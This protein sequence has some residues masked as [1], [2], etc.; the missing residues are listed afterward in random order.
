MFSELR[1]DKSLPGI[2]IPKK[3]ERKGLITLIQQE[4]SELILFEIS[5]LNYP[6]KL[7]V[8]LRFVLMSNKLFRDICNSL[9]VIVW[10][11]MYSKFLQ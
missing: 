6:R 11:M 3:E 4:F 1:T 10:Q 9:K 8:I 7:T 5:I 2:A